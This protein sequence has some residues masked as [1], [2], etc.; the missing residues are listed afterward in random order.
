MALVQLCAERAKGKRKYTKTHVKGKTERSNAYKNKTPEERKDLKEQFDLQLQPRV[1]RCRL[2]LLKLTQR[3]QHWMRIWFKDARKTYNLSLQY[4]LE[5]GWHRPTNSHTTNQMESQLIARFVTAASGVQPKILLRT[6]KVIRQEAVKSLLSTIKT[7][8]TNFEQRLSLRA[9]YPNAFS[10]QKDVKFRPKFKS[11]MN[12]RHDSIHIEKVSGLKTD[13]RSFSCFKH[14]KPDSTLP[15]KNK[16]TKPVFRTVKTRDELPNDCFDSDFAIHFNHGQFYL[17]V[18][19]RVNPL[20]LK[21]RAASEVDSVC[22]IDPGVRKFATVYS[23]EGQMEFLGINTNKVIDK[24][25]RRINR[26][27]KRLTSLKG[28][29]PKSR[30]D[31]KRWRVKMQKHIRR[32]L[33]SEQKASEVVKNM[34][35]NFAHHLCSSYKTVIYPDINLTSAVSTSKDLSTAV[36]LRISQLRFGRFKERL[37]QT[38][39]VYGTDILTGSE[40]FTSKQCGKCGELNNKLG[41]SETWHCPSCG[42]EADRDGHAARNIFLRFLTSAPAA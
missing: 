16:K 36:K 8:R 14:W 27:K 41:K 1:V 39:S 24:C 9:K 3:Q 5:Q 20:E 30:R 42:C 6:P 32:R 25:I 31:R 12:W 18:P 11:R 4:L 7:F 33:A 37:S 10:F 23:P 26:R 21:K 22:A 13:L 40:A 29:K 2:N 35:Y 19:R 15:S 38:A 34:H 17:Q 28:K